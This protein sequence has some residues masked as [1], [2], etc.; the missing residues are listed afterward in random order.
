MITKSAKINATSA[1]IQGQQ[2]RGKT[3]RNRLRQIDY[4]T[5]RYDRHVL[6]RKDGLFAQA[7]WLDLGYGAEPFTTLETA[8]RF[9][10][11]HRS[12]PVIGVEIAQDRVARALPYADDKTDFRLGGFNYPLHDGENIRAIRAFN[13]LR[14]YEE[15]AVLDAYDA[16][17]QQLLPN[18]LL[19]EGTCHPFG[20]YSVTNMVRRVANK[21]DGHNGQHYWKIEAMVFAHRFKTAFSPS[22]FQTVLPK[23]LIHKVTPGHHIYDFFQDWKKQASL[24]SHLKTWGHRQWFVGTA[25]ALAQDGYHIDCR[26]WWLRHGI[27]IWRQ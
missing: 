12:L 1:K 23:N 5:L 11:A 25:K 14:Q 7:A 8:R 20:Q 27:L 4:I 9:R 26:K 16:M 15:Q 22:D 18:G 24:N 21:S 10:Q 13:V 2:T 6:T 17:C 3:A 19:V